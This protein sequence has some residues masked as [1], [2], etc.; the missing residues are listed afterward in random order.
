MSALSTFS[1]NYELVNNIDLTLDH[2]NI[3]HENIPAVPTE[4]IP[5]EAMQ[6]RF[7]QNCLKKGIIRR[8]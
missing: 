5:T 1:D 8:K 7:L 2:I 4:L 6:E 3:D